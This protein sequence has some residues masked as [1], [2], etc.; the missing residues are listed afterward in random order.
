MQPEP[1]K[2]HRTRRFATAASPWLTCGLWCLLLGLEGCSG[3]EPSA[4]V[5]KTTAALESAG[6]SVA[7]P[8]PQAPA[9]GAAARR[10]V[11]VEMEGTPALAVAAATRDW[12]ARGT[13]VY[14]ALRDS[15]NASQ[16][17]VRELLARKGLQYKAHW[18]V[19]AIR[20]EADETTIRELSQRRDVRRVFD[21]GTLEIPRP[22]PGTER[23]RVAAVE[24][25]IQNIRASEAWSSFG[26]RGEGIVVA[27][28]DTGAQF[29]HP[30]LVGQY[31]GNLGDGTFDHNY[32]WHDP[33]SICGFPSMAPCDNAGHGTH[34]MGTIVGDD[35]GDNQIGV[36]PGARWIAAKGCE[37]YSCSYEA[38]LSSGEWMLAPTDVNGTNPRP[39]LRPHIVSNS[40]G[41]GGGDDFYRAVVQAWVA[42]G[43]F[44][45]F[46]NGNSGSYCESS[47]S[48]G[49]YPESYAVGAYDVSEILADFSS[50]GPSWYEVI[51]PNIA[52]P[53]VDVRS[54]V[55]GNDYD[56]Y[57]G[58]SMAAPHVAGAVALLWSASANSLGDVQSTR[59]LFDESAI[60]H[61]D[62]SCG[63][64][65]SNNNAWGQGK[66]DVME[67]LAIAPIGPS[68]YLSGYVTAADGTPIQRASVTAIGE[69]SRTVSTD[70]TGAYSVR[71]SVGSYQVEASAFGYYGESA[72]AAVEEN[73]TTDLD[74]SLNAAPSFPVE[75]TVTD[76]QGDPL[77][78]ARVSILATPLPAQVTDESGHF[79][80]P[81]V[82]VGT[83]ALNVSRGGCY[84][85]SVLDLTVDDAEDV[86]VTLSNKVDS[87][88][89]QCRP[90]TFEY[91]E[92]E[93]PINVNSNGQTSVTLPFPVTL[94]DGTYDSLIVS[95]TGYVAADSDWSS[96]YNESIPNPN[97]PN[98]AIYAFWDDVW[99][100]DDV[101]V[102]TLGEAPN[103]RFVIEWRDVYLYSSGMYTD[104]EVV[105][106]ETGEIVMQYPNSSD[107]AS[108]GS[109]AT[110]GIENAAGDVALEYSYNQAS[111]DTGTAV[112]YEVPFA[113][114]VQGVV[115]D[116]NDHLPVAGARVTAR[117]AAGD[118]RVARTNSQ[119][120]YRMMLSEGAYTLTITRDN[121]GEA[122][123]SVTVT[124]DGTFYQ[125][126][127]LETATVILSSPTLQ[128]VVPEDSVR[129]R[130]ITITNGGSLALDFELLEAG[131]ARQEIVRTASLQRNPDADP[132]A[133]STVDLYLDRPRASGIR[134]TSA[135]DVIRSFTPSGVD[136]PWGVVEAGTL[137]VS[138]QNAADNTEFALDGTPTGIVH[139]A[140]WAGWWPT[141]MAF[142]STR[143]LVCQLASGNDN[144]INCWNPASGEVEVR[145]S[146]DAWTGYT[147]LGL[148][149]NP[150]DDT[151]FVGGWSTGTIYHV[152]GA[153]HDDPGAVISSCNPPDGNI[154][155]L[156][157]NGAMDVLWVA[158][159]SYE[160][161]IYEVNPYDCTV[162]STMAPPYAGEWRGAGLDMD[163]SGNLWMVS[164]SPSRVYLV[165]SGV[166]AISDIPWLVAEPTAGTVPSLGNTSI[167]ITIDTSGLEP[168]LYLG[169]LVLDSNA[170]RTPMLRI[171]VSL[172][173][174][175]YMHAINSGGG[176]YT[177]TLE[178]TWEKDR[179][180]VAGGYGYVQ[181][182][183]AK[184]TKHAISGTDDQTLFKSQRENV[185]AYRYDNVPNGI[186]QI[187]LNFA[188]FDSVRLGARIFDVIVEDELVLPAHDIMY[189]V[190]R[191]AADE[192]R[193]FIEVTDE[194][195]DIRLVSSG[196][197]RNPVLNAVRV[198]HRPDL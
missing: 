188:E 155:G 114:F 60:D 94:Y 63:G 108:Q 33:S 1:V 39:D 6:A 120:V 158:T 143:N 2:I 130:E 50:R 172:V 41:G 145:I 71:L 179:A 178:E 101:Y 78:G 146:G 104:F 51:K 187:D 28:I 131:A 167:A 117:N 62:T 54:S 38:L 105:L 99:T 160:D 100:D 24:W 121:Y 30:A 77:S 169:T 46:S 161:T 182:G 59:E 80:F 13:A 57:S 29:D 123:A 162:I 156:A 58:T 125:D 10:A 22:L 72:E 118:E 119:G 89:Y 102:A 124:E 159:N 151:F 11:W 21:D 176:E 141:D 84:A 157:Y 4:S 79:M 128:L 91:L 170:G 19:N 196:G 23:Q 112:L 56:W 126:V 49:D 111:V 93:T 195:V 64:D 74:F 136:Y 115:G 180:Y 17:G 16:A 132:R 7:A 166:P 173:V 144:A 20:V 107:P 67:T 69:R 198:V 140:P 31:R 44:P 138:D 92:G 48:P 150:A 152:W 87:F 185:Y 181:G 14:R 45:V 127:L 75:G 9:A 190:G 154:S 194:R 191:F 184:S 40:W 98:G 97:V 53:G 83:Y 175:G 171:P 61:N 81:A 76:A 47:G 110:I 186:Y 153:S 12:R 106:Y 129:T 52:A 142:D 26:T 15:A 55:P 25:N 192:N 103:R 165:E 68:G 88:G 3:E 177:D 90:V 133:T 183:K 85:D 147:E 95:S 149:Y 96:Y 189:E 66:L 135:G 116:G 197:R 65:A 164:Q 168:G 174:S 34:T 86:P 37:D 32:N 137:W 148:A 43:I 35:G 8:A 73:L 139:S 36:A 18:I 134:P 70:A 193:F 27:T 5:S 113:G 82:P 122:T 109:S 42:A 163:P